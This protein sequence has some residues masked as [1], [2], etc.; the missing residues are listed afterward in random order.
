M[1]VKSVFPEQG[2]D[3]DTLQARF[4]AIAFELAYGS[5]EKTYHFSDT[6]EKEIQEWKNSLVLEAID[7][8][9]VYGTGFGYS[10]KEL[11]SW[12]HERKERKLVFFE[13]NISMLDTLF[14]QDIGSEILIDPQVYFYYVPDEKMWPQIF[15]ECVCRFLSDRIEWTAL[16]SSSAG[17]EKKVRALRLKLFRKSTAVHAKVGELLHYSL[18]MQNIGVNLFHL[19]DSFHANQLK[20]KFKNV[21]AIIC[22]AG[23]SLKEEIELLKGLE[24]KALVIA[25][26]SA[27]TALGHYGIRPHMAMAVDPNEEEYVRLKTSSCFE[28]PFVYSSRLHKDVLS[29]THMQMGYLCSNTG[30]LFEA[31]VHDKLGIHTKS[32]ALELGEEALSVTTLATA[33]AVHMG[34]NPIIFCGVDLSYSNGQ[35]YCP[36]VVSS[37]SVSKKELEKVTRSRDRMIRRKNIK[38]QFVQ[39]LIKWVMEAACL[40]SYAKKH[41]GT[42][43]FNLSKEGLPIPKAQVITKEELLQSFCTHD[44]DLRGW[45]RAESEM[46]EF[47]Q[48]ARLVLDESFTKLKKSFETS[49]TLFKQMLHELHERKKKVDDLSI[50]LDSGK[51]S[52]IEMDLVEEPAFEVCFQSVFS[53]YQGILEWVNTSSLSIEGPKERLR[54]L[55]NKEKV[56]KSGLKVAED[57]LAFLKNY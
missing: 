34:C 19:P 22:G 4:P 26:G 18:L 33:F 20:G 44:Y 37:S 1:G 25:G 3:W 13:D 51:M 42:Q 16:R 6:I 48:D 21:P 39:T 54:F 24:Q 45:L 10:Y 57:C 5:Y 12:L 15:E 7:V 55:E 32:F 23:S 36:G 2:I 9:Y 50:P 35:R 28:A 41:P 40:G 14:H 52:I 11:K 43:F 49:S 56:W 8:L 29:S 38:G 47:P 30:G 31:W 53:V 46:T 17:R 27:I